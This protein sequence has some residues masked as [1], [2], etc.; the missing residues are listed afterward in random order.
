L[1]SETHFS[2]A[3]HQCFESIAESRTS[4]ANHEKPASAHK[5]NGLEVCGILTV[6]AVATS[7]PN[8]LRPA[9]FLLL[10]MGWLLVLSSII[11]LNRNGALAAFSLA[12]LAVEILG[13]VLVAR[14]F[15]APRPEH[16]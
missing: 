11:L 15:I 8:P 4:G 9:G 2:Y 1:E 12:G 6:M 13:L 3:G 10:V 5:N 14:S 16:N 7:K